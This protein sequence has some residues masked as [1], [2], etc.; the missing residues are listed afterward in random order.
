MNSTILAGG[1][2]GPI[3]HIDPITYSFPS[4]FEG[5]TLSHDFI[6][7][8]RGSTDLEIKDVTHQWGCVVT[9][10]DRVIP[11]GGTGTVTLAVDTSRV[12]GEFQKRAVVWSNDSEQ[13]SVALYLKGEVTPLISLEPGGYVGLWG[14]K[15]QVP[16]ESIEIINNLNNSVN[17]A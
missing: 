3:I 14:V 12:I 17:I 7:T 8:N 9:R 6:V 1:P 11:P 15:G 16:V 5:Q 2:D 10:Y 4:A 13:R